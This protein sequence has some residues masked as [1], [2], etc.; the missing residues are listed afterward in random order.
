MLIEK[1]EST[2]C[3]IGFKKRKEQLSALTDNSNFRPFYFIYNST[4][5]KAIFCFIVF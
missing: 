5:A 2:T 1:I 3:M 4:G